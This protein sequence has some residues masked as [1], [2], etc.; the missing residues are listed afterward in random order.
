MLKILVTGVFATGKTTL[1]KKV[2]DIA[3]REDGLQIELVQDVARDE[4]V[5]QNKDQTYLSTLAHFGYH[6]GRESEAAF[7]SNDIILCDRGIPDILSH[8]LEMLEAVGSTMIGYDTFVESCKS[9][10]EHYDKIV[11]CF[12]G[13]EQ[14]K[15]DGVRIKDEKYRRRLGRRMDEIFQAASK[16]VID[17]PQE[18]EDRVQTVMA[19]IRR[20]RQG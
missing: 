19:I 18:T 3:T 13:K 10:L 11:R 14:I 12:P 4:D 8:A 7:K 2:T 16:E 15:D 5:P 20:W 17:L 6:L 1:V 9:W